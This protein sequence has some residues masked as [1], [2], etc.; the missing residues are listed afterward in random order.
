MCMIFEDLIE[1][2]IGQIIIRAD[3]THILEVKFGSS[4]AI[5]SSPNA[6][7]EVCKEQLQE[8]FSHKRTTFSIPLDPK[9]TDFQRSVWNTIQTI[10]FGKTDFYANIASRIKNPLAVRGVGG[11]LGKNPIVIIIPCHR[12]IG[13]NKTLTG[14]TG[15]IDKKAWLLEHENQDLSF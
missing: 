7:T 14:F 4:D 11:A 5:F 12:I 2:P 1:T 15:G 8:Y 9:G 10:P 6:I 3:D 13:K